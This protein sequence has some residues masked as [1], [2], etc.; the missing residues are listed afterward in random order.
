[1]ERK[2]CTSTIIGNKNSLH[3][4]LGPIVLSALSLLVSVFVLQPLALFLDPTFDLTASRGIG[5]VAFVTMVIYQFLLFLLVLAKTSDHYKKFLDDFFKRNLF[6][7]I[8]EKWV[9][10]FSIFFISFFSLHAM[11][12]LFI[13]NQGYIFYQ[14]D[15]GIINL[16][17]IGKTLFGLFVVFMLAWTEEL[18]FRGTIY[19]YFRQFYSTLTS[20]FVTSMIFMLAHN[21]KGIALHQN[22]IAL[23]T[24]EWKLG[25]G[26]FLLGFLLNQVF[27]VT[28]KLYTGMGLH[29]GLVF[30]K[31]IIRRAPI[32]AYIPEN[33]WAWW[34]NRDL[35]QSHLTHIL[36]IATIIFIFV[37]YKKHFF[38]NQD[39]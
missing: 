27:V 6:F 17:L 10:S 4:S 38:S 20:L 12:I 15:W 34:I 31:V 14:P 13:Y 18:I 32:I 16:A 11:M 7:F 8:R 3:K 23:V 37:R 5:K 29:A 22:P 30:T 21:L 36:F 19:P 25:L 35:R 24:T 33:Q 1:M 26:L 2:D 39:L 9:P 28:K